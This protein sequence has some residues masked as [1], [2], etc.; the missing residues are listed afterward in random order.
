[1]RMAVCGISIAILVACGSNTLLAQSTDEIKLIKVKASEVEKIIAQHKGK[2]VA[3]DVWADFCLPCKKAFPHLVQLHKQHA[4]AGLICISLSTDLDENYEGA[5]AFLKKQGAVFS[6]YILWDSE[7]NKDKLQK[8]FAH[9]AVPIFHLYDREGK[10]VKTW[11]GN[12][13]AEEIDK[14]VEELLKKK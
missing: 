5:L 14:L 12:L 4:Q 2:V 11:D 10:R 8:T 7:E 3:V 1:M 9:V 6:N 13:K